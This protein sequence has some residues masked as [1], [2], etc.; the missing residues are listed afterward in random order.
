MGQ[1]GAEVN[2]GGLLLYQ[3]LELTPS[4]LKGV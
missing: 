3:T 4:G 2:A 1:E